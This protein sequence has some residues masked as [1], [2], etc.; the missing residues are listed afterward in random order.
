MVNYQV[1][2]HATQSMAAKRNNEKDILPLHTRTHV[3]E[4]QV[5]HLAKNKNKCTVVHS[6]V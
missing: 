3:L 5:P 1:A 4:A 2:F 6:D